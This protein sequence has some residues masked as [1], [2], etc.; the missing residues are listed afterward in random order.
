M[1]DLKNAVSNAFQTG[2]TVVM[3]GERTMGD[4]AAKVL[5][6]NDVPCRTMFSVEFLL[7][8]SGNVL[9]DVVFL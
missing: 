6:D 2:L 3:K 7:D 9:L 8:L 1:E 5:S 4:I